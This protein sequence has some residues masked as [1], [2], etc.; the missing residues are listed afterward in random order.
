[1]NRPKA[2][3]LKDKYGIKAILLL[4]VSVAIVIPALILLLSEAKIRIAVNLLSGIGLLC[5]SGGLLLAVKT[6]YLFSCRGKGTIAPWNPPT[7]LIWEGPYL[8]VRNPMLSGIGFMLLG[9]LML[10]LNDGLAVWMLIFMI[11]NA[12][13]IPYLEEPGLL[14]RFGVKYRVYKENVPRWIPR[15]TAWNPAQSLF[16]ECDASRNDANHDAEH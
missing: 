16:I 14:K 15:R 12:L 5:F 7:Q 8:H 13:Y 6:I 9:E 4:P 3:I 1:M 10:F 2:E 11:A